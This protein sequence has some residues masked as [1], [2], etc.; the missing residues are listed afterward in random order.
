MPR[1]FPGRVFTRA[2]R[3][4]LSFLNLEHDLASLNDALSL[5]LLFSANR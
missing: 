4:V 2:A 1:V 3:F 5:L